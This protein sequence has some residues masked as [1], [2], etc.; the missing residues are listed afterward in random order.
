[1][2]GIGHVGVNPAM[3]TVCPSPLL[4]SLIDLNPRQIEGI[5]IETLRL[6]ENWLGVC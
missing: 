4:L 5:D 2:A 6:Q 1:V 3:G